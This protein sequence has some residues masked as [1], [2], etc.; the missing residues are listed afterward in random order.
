ME[1]KLKRFV[2]ELDEQVKR[3][4]LPPVLNGIQSDVTK[5][6]NMSEAS[7]R[8][9]TEEDCATAAALIQQESTLIQQQVNRCHSIMKWAEQRIQWIIAPVVNN[10]PG[11]GYQERRILAIRQNETATK[12]E[13]ER[14]KAECLSI[15]IGYISLR[16]EN[17][18]RILADVMK[19]KV[20]K[21]G[22]PT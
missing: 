17:Q 18:A 12:Y 16:L 14:M 2:H 21:N 10:M 20:R 13:E 9:L 19:V 6:L 8:G 3:L 15:D 4:A 5:Y 7:L 11:Y 1:E 22:K